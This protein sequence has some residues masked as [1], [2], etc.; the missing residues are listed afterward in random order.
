MQAGSIVSRSTNFS[1]TLATLQGVLTGLYPAATSTPA[2]VTV[3]SDLDEMLYADSKKCPH[4][5]ALINMGKHAARGAPHGEK[6][7]GLV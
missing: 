1:R 6:T 7:G 4:L 5:A 2:P 3:S